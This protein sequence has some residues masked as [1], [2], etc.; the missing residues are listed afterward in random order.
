MLKVVHPVHLTFQ[1]QFGRTKS[2][3]LCL[4]LYVESFWKA[5]QQYVNLNTELAAAITVLSGDSACLSDAVLLT[6]QISKT[7]NDA[8]LSDYCHLFDS[9]H[10]I[11]E[12]KRLWQLRTK[13]VSSFAHLSL[14][15]D[16]RS[17]HKHFAQNEPL[18]V[19]DVKQKT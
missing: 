5:A 7:V 17:K 6:M 4:R 14:L 16:P 18:I 15:L 2:T 12:L 9:E 19:G 8:S 11:T 13:R 3:Q 1:T 10:Q